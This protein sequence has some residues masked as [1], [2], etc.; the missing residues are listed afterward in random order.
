MMSASLARQN[1]W[2]FEQISNPELKKAKALEYIAYYL[3]RIEQHL[4][5]IAEQSKDR[6]VQNT[7]AG[8]VNALVQ[9]LDR[10][11]KE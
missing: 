10:Q 9:R 4:A 11:A 1:E 3:D 7:I 8:G 5:V 2:K 6:G